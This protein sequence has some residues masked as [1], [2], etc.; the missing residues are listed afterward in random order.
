MYILVVLLVII[1]V[2]LDGVLAD[3]GSLNI[4]LA[5]GIEL[6]AIANILHRVLEHPVAVLVGDVLHG[7]LHK[8]IEVAVFTAHSATLTLLFPDD[9]SIV[10]LVIHL[11]VESVLGIFILV[12][13]QFLP[14]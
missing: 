5:L 2:Q 14:V 7:A 13:L 6:G 9:L 1:L 12:A 11:G 4:G 8:A 10:D 3:E